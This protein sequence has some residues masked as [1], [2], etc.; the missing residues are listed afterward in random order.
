MRELVGEGVLKLDETIAG[1]QDRAGHWHSRRQ[2]DAAACAG[3]APISAWLTGTCTS[4]GGLLGSD[5]G[6]L[7]RIWRHASD[8]HRTAVSTTRPDVALL[9]QARTFNHRWPDTSV[10]NLWRIRQMLNRIQADLYLY[11]EAYRTTID[12][13]GLEATIA[14]HG[15]SL[16]LNAREAVDFVA[17]ANQRQTDTRRFGHGNGDT[18]D[19]T[20]DPWFAAEIRGRLERSPTVLV[21]MRTDGRLPLCAGVNAGVACLGWLKGTPVERT[22]VALHLPAVVAA[23]AVQLTEGNGVAAASSDETDPATIA[24][25]VTLWHDGGSYRDLDAALAAAR[26]V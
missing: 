26:R 17:Y 2:C 20:L 7:L 24:T 11:A 8:L 3:K 4:C 15:V 23:G 16:S 18:L 10:S 22:T 6:L 9:W 14:T 25:A 21:V 12:T 1:W 19:G 13:A 5:C